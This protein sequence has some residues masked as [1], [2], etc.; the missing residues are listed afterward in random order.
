MRDTAS[1]SSIQEVNYSESY[2]IHTTPLQMFGDEYLVKQTI[3]RY[4]TEGLS[5]VPIHQLPETL[6]KSRYSFRC[7]SQPFHD[8][9]QK[10]SH[11]AEME[12]HWYNALMIR[13]LC[14]KNLALFRFYYS[15]K[16]LTTMCNS[17]RKPE[18]TLQAQKTANQA[19]PGKRESNTLGDSTK[20]AAAP[21]LMK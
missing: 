2:L 13:L 21:Y 8:F 14:Y 11:E 10:F 16:K 18:E 19:F 4:I 17:Q 15:S 5:S 3:L 6:L 1:G 12:M 20:T 7:C 9:S